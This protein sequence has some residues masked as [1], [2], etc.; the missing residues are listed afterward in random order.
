MKLLTPHRALQTGEARP[1][2]RQVPRPARRR[3]VRVVL[4]ALLCLYLLTDSQLVMPLPSGEAQVAD[5]ATFNVDSTADAVDAN[6]GNGVCATE[7]NACTLRAAIQE[8][9]A[10]PGTDTINLLAGVYTLSLGPAGDEIASSGDLDI[11]GTVTI[12]GPSLGTGMAII[13]GNASDR[14]IEIHSGSVTIDRIG[15]RN[16]GLSAGGI[17][18]RNNA[19]LVLTNS[20][21]SGNSGGGLNNLSSGTINVT[22]STIS[23]NKSTTKT[24][25][26]NGYSYIVGGIGAGIANLYSTLTITN[27]TISGNIAKGKRI[28]SYPYFA[29]GLAGGILNFGSSSNLTLSGGM[30]TKNTATIAGGG[31]ANISGTYTYTPGT[32]TG[33]KAKYYANIFTY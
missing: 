31:L 29:G 26:Y 21:L 33:N 19:S 27:S 23:G 1:P 25:T 12:N 11:T 9:N 17:L 32:I 3:L 6:I 8:A 18:V 20:T 4:S 14:A 22:N 13:D 15:I 2:S 24:I 28:R 10:S 16:G 30:V 5:A 7:T